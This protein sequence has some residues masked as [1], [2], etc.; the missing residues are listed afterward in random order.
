MLLD[1]VGE[2]EAGREVEET[3]AELIRSGR[4][5]GLQAGEHRCSELGTM[6]RDHLL[7]RAR[8]RR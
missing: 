1:H 7:E 4:I 6:V 8:A 5:R 2:Q 3:V